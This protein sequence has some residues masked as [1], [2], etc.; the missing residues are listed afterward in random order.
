MDEPAQCCCCSL[1]CGSKCCLMLQ[2]DVARA[3]DCH[4]CVE[5]SKKVPW[6]NGHNKQIFLPNLTE[7][8]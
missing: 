5:R 8:F 3:M 4:L 2:L 1:C 7:E 6:L